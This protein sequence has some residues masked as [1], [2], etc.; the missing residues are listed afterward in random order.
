MEKRYKKTSITKAMELGLVAKSN[1]NIKAGTE[2]SHLFPVAKMKEY[3]IN[4]NGSVMD[5]VK[6]MAKIV[7]EK[8]KDDTAKLAPLLIGSN[9]EDTLRKIWQFT[10]DHIRYKLDKPGIEQ[11]RS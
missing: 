4:G 11:L 6:A 5:T 8:G 1:R 9:L 2:F 3:I 10:Y 7:R